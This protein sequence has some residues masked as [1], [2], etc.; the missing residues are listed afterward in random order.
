MLRAIQGEARFSTTKGNTTVVVQRW[1]RKQQR[2]EYYYLDRKLW[3]PRGGD[4]HQHRTGLAGTEQNQEE[5]SR[6]ED[7][8]EEASVTWTE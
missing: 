5:F 4:Q 7:L 1:G 2:S 3:G 6:Q 8:E